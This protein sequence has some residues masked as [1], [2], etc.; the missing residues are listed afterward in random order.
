MSALIV[1]RAQLNALRRAPKWRAK[2]RCWSGVGSGSKQNA[3]SVQPSGG[4]NPAAATITSCQEGV[5]VNPSEITPSATQCPPGSI[6]P[7]PTVR[8][9]TTTDV[10]RQLLILPSTAPTGSPAFRGSETSSPSQNP[11][12]AADLHHGDLLRARGPAL[13]S[14]I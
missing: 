14:R 12:P 3:C 1:S 7:H 5:T 10:R 6:P 4:E 13:T 11:R 2:A 8:H 9:N